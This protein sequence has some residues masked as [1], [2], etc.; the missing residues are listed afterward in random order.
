MTQRAP[1]SLAAPVV[2]A[3]VVYL[4]SFESGFFSRMLRHTPFR[5]FGLWSYSIY[6][7]RALILRILIYAVRSV[8]R[9]TGLPLRAA[10]DSGTGYTVM[11]FGSDAAM[12]LLCARFLLTVVATSSLTYRFVEEPARLYFNALA[13]GRTRPIEQPRPAE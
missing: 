11:A 4:F 10:A 8:E 6:M 13:R 12:S 7:V 9:L 2:F 1:S 5:Q 3:L